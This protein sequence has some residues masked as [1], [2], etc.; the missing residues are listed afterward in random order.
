MAR[1][2]SPT[3]T[4]AELRLMEA[5]WRLG[6]A[7]VNEV[8]AALPDDQ[9]LAYNTVLT[10]LRILEKKGYLTHKKDGRAHVYKPLVDRNQARHRAVKH[11][12]SRFFNNSPEALALH[13]LE[14]EGVSPEEVARLK[15]LIEREG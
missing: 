7:S 9:N 12:V 6:S 14:A 2:Q 10:T 5:I 11:M 1:K 4:D 13:I 8:I 3:L 15:K